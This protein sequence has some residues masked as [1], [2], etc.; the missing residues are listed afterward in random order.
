MS[1]FSPQFPS[2]PT[3]AGATV[4]TTTFPTELAPFIKDILE[5]AKA[6]QSDASYQA[7][8][9]PQLAQFSDKETA[10]MNAI[11]NQATGLAGTDVAQAAPYFQGAKTAVE[12]LGQQFTGDTAQQYMNP[13]QQA[14]VDQAKAKAVEDY[15][16]KIAPGIAAQAVASQPFGGS[17]QAIAEGMARQDLTDKLTEI[18]ERGSADAFNQ[19]RAAFE[20]QK[21]RELQQGQ[22]FAQ[23]GQTIPQQA[24][25]DL[26][27]QQQIG[28]Q[29][30]QQEQRGLDLAKSQFMEE[31]EFPTRAL[32]EYSAVVRGFPFQPSTYTAQTQYQPTPSI[33]SQLL[34]L[35]GA[36]L[37][38]YTQFGGQIPKLFGATGG[39]IADIIHNQE[40]TNEQNAGLTEESALRTTFINNQKGFDIIDGE[41]TP[42]SSEEFHNRYGIGGTQRTNIESIIAPEFLPTE[43]APFRIQ[44]QMEES[45]QGAPMGGPLPSQEEMQQQ[46]LNEQLQNRPAFY[47]QGGLVTVYNQAGENDQ[48]VEEEEEKPTNQENI[49]Y[50]QETVPALVGKSYFEDADFSTPPTITQDDLTAS[51]DFMAKRMPEG[52]AESFKDSIAYIKEPKNVFESQAYKEATDPTK[53]ILK[54]KDLEQTKLR[55]IADPTSQYSLDKA[56]RDRRAEQ[57]TFGQGLTKAALSIDPNASFVQQL[58]TLIGGAGDAKGKA[59]TE[60]DKIIELDAQKQANAAAGIVTSETNYLNALNTIEKNVLAGNEMELNK[61]L[62]NVKMQINKKIQDN[63]LTGD[64]LKHSNNVQLSLLDKKIAA[65][66]AGT[67]QD[68]LKIERAKVADNIKYANVKLSIES[69][70]AET[71]RQRKLDMT[72]LDGK[73]IQRDYDATI[74]TLKQKNIFDDADLKAINATIKDQFGMA[75]DTDGVLRYTGSKAAVEDQ[76][77]LNAYSDALAYALGEASV[78]KGL[79]KGIT[80]S[81]LIKNISLFQKTRKLGLNPLIYS[82]IQINK[83]G[84]LEAQFGK[85]VGTR[86]DFIVKVLNQLE[87]NTDPNNKDFGYLKTNPYGIQ[88]RT[89]D[90]LEEIKR[91]TSAGETTV[92]RQV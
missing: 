18:Q 20:A 90:G 47:N 5:K 85:H 45:A 78:L 73:K 76:T 33:G 71:D 41:P 6:Q 57:I 48:N 25:R 11:V 2:Q 59:T 77:E 36:G 24:L 1:I 66:R 46:F 74:A 69:M 64:L 9:G 52:T 65:T 83:P 44:M 8:T 82:A 13:Y 21:G 79:G 34:Q 61:H 16:S 89:K 30:R 26:A 27:I 4:A 54:A 40:G 39:G 63:L 29:E 17:R 58:S 87:T 80:S 7:Y 28:E 70:L 84:E 43:P 19:G 23:L 67:E 10:A 37:G 75:Y 50:N 72:K 55:D 15:E 35:G 81:N 12:G 38:A 53:G 62:T 42:I 32:Q 49:V 51:L 56:E 31:R 92:P 86:N 22:Q 91:L 88:V 60:Y 14:V 68:A 3:P